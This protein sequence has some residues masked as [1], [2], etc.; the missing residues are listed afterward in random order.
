ME[1]EEES[2]GSAFTDLPCLL[3]NVSYNGNLVK[4]FTT[5]HMISVN[6]YI[7]S[8]QTENIKREQESVRRTFDHLAFPTPLKIDAPIA[9]VVMVRLRK[10]EYKNYVLNFW[11]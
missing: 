6:N 11:S 9:I 2:C 1:A 7:C 5:T 10:R 8:T 4:G 3:R